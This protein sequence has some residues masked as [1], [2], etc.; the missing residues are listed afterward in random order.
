MARGQ[1]FHRLMVK[2][3]EHPFADEKT[4]QSQPEL[5]SRRML[6][7]YMN[8]IHVMFGKARLDTYEERARRLIDRMREAA[9][10]RLDWNDVYKAPEA[11]KLTLLAEVDIAR[12]FED[13]DKRLEWM[14]AVI[15]S[16][17]IPADEHLTGTPW[18]FNRS[19]AEWMMTSLLANLRQTIKKDN[20]RRTI[21]DRV[22]TDVLAVLDDV[23]A[24][25]A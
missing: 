16:N 22:G 17:L 12:R 14:I 21:A 8:M 9:G 19:A 15:N 11:R 24:R 3:F 23:T 4:L 7:G 1:L 18:A 6:P 25:F 5:L 10:G 20:T 13:I 2:K